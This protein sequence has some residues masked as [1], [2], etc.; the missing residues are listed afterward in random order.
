MRQNR[1][2]QNGLYQI[3][4]VP[5]GAK[6]LLTATQRAYT[7]SIGFKLYFPWGARVIENDSLNSFLPRERSY[8]SWVLHQEAETDQPFHQSLLKLNERLSGDERRN[9]ALLRLIFGQHS[10][11]RITGNRDRLGATCRNRNSTK[12]L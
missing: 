5:Q 11:Y 8:L 6:A 2:V 9:N 3:P 10:L 1:K 12:F 4:T 7:S